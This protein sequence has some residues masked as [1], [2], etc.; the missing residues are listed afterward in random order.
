[1]MQ[2]IRELNLLLFLKKSFSRR[3]GFKGTWVN[4]CRCQPAGPGAGALC[5]QPQWAF[6]S[7]GSRD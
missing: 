3:I 1:M 5:G 4:T 2:I 7:L 6:C